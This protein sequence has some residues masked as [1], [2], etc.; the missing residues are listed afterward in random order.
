MCK[1]ERIYMDV[2]A[3][4]VFTEC[5]YFTGMY[6]HETFNLELRPGH[7]RIDNTCQTNKDHD[8]WNEETNIEGCVKGC[9]SRGARII[10]EVG[11]I[12]IG[13]LCQALL[14]IDYHTFDGQKRS[15]V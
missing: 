1:R 5:E 2:N 4:G 12:A 3:D 9:I 8:L 6:I 13:R 7:N 15:I 11:H 10:W 14:P